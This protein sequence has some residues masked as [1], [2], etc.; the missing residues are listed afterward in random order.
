MASS[1]L[2][3]MEDR[4][5]APMLPAGIAPE[6]VRDLPGAEL[7]LPGLTDLDRGEPSLNAH[8]ASLA[9]A[10]LTRLG[11]RVPSP[12]H[13]PEDGAYAILAGLGEDSAH[14][15]YNAL[16]RRVTSFEHATAHLVRWSADARPVDRT[17]LDEFLRALGRV[18]R[19]PA[20]C[21][22]NGGATAIVYGWRD[23]SIDVDLLIEPE[24]DELFA[25]IGRLKDELQTNVEFASPAGFI[26][27]PPDW[28]ER[29]PLVTVEGRLSVRHL[30]LRTQA[31]A[32]IERGHARDVA[33]VAAML[34]RELVS[35]YNLRCTFEQLEPHLP[36]FPAIDPDDFRRKLED[37][38]GRPDRL[39]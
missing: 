9:A 21:Y 15:R 10:N 7:V 13:R 38:L 18:A 25:A 20:T 4:R 5:L 11:F 32:K 36:R 12:L 27:M 29:S 2:A 22:L 39:S 23:S 35:R 3:A 14:G 37:A 6:D 30:D 28:R 34:E 8:L 1:R 17:R 33:D 26:P 24:R 19:E 16:V 31:L